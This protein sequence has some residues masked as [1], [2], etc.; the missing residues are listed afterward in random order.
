MIQAKWSESKSSISTWC[1]T[2]FCSWYKFSCHSIRNRTRYRLNFSWCS[3]ITVVYDFCARFNIK[4]RKQTSNK[5]LSEEKTAS[6]HKHLAYHLGCIKR[7]YDDGLDEETAQN[8]DDTNIVI[9]IDNQRSKYV[10]YADVA[11]RRDCFTLCMRIS[12][13]QQG[14]FEKPLVFFQ[15]SI[16]T[17]QL[18]EYHMTSKV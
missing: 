3:I 5:S 1:S 16:A 15:N 14:K 17:I 7:E 9:D 6:V 18:P 13:G 11:S 4:I 12:S 10:T 2:S 8:F